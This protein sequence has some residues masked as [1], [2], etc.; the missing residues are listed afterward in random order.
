MYSLSAITIRLAGNYTPLIS[1]LTFKHILLVRT[2]PPAESIC[3]GVV[4][5]VIGRLCASTHDTITNECVAIVSNNTS[6]RWDS[7]ENEPTIMLGVFL[8]CFSLPMV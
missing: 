5:V 7:I 1:T 4:M 8:D 3:I 6:T 2:F